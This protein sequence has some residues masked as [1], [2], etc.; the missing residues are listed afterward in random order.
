M[1]PKT[2][3]LEASDSSLTPLETSLRKPYRVPQIVTYGTLA[4][5]T[6]GFPGTDGANQQ[7]F[8]NPVN[9]ACAKSHP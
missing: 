6:K 9:Q 3:E 5:I 4:E 7:G 8:C 2:R 1:A